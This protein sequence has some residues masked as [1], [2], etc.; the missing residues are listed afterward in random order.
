MSLEL[1]GW[2]LMYVSNV[3][4]LLLIS[5]IMIV[6]VQPESLYFGAPN[7]LPGNK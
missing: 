2:L 1:L 7:D 3:I 5:M 4:S 6:F